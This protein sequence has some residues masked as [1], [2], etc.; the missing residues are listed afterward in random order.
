[1]NDNSIEGLA[2]NGELHPLQESFREEHALPSGPPENRHSPPPTLL[3]AAVQDR[4]CGQV[5]EGLDADDPHLPEEGIV[6][7]I[8]SSQRACMGGG[9]PRA[10][11]GRARH[12]SDLG[13]LPDAT[14]VAAGQLVQ[15]SECLR[16]KDAVT[17]SQSNQRIADVAGRVLGFPGVHLNPQLAQI[18]EL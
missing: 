12:Q 10:R 8:V 13:Q 5:G 17:A 14:G 16:L 15:A 1:M 2:T 7:L 11:G 9:G 18:V 6:D 4:E 3:S